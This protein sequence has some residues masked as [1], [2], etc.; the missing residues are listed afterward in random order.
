[1]SRSRTRF[2]EA[3]SGLLRGGATGDVLPR[4]SSLAERAA[5]DAGAAA[6]FAVA[7]SDGDGDAAGAALARFF[8]ALLSSTIHTLSLR[9]TRFSRCSFC[10]LSLCSSKRRLMSPS[11]S[12]GGGGSGSEWRP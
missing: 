9:K 2:F 4:L 10:S 3:S 12:T 7:A 11:L 6:G 5:A 8:L 1:M